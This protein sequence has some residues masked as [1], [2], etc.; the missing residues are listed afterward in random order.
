MPATANPKPLA[1]PSNN[2]LPAYQFQ[3]LDL[4]DFETALSDISECILEKRRSDLRHKVSVWQ[5]LIRYSLANC[6]GELLLDLRA[7]TVSGPVTTTQRRRIE[8]ML[9]RA[10]D[11]PLT[12]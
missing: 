6:Q 4:S 11:A 12:V 10:M 8:T 5:P 9:R 1:T 2:M 3:S 7:L